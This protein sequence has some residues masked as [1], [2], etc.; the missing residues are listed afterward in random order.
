M[1]WRAWC[2]TS[3]AT[4]HRTTASRTIHS[5]CAR[6]AEEL[7]D[8]ATFLFKLAYQ[9]GIDMEAALVDNQRKAT[10]RY[11]VEQGQADT[12]RYLARQTENL[13]RMKG[14]NE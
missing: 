1:R 8:C 12:A 11:T 6:L 3:T 2:S 5:F 10:E 14:E 9:Y 7:A 13:A 4:T